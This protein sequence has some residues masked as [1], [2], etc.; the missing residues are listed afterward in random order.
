MS[1][2]ISLSNKL[3]PGCSGNDKFLVH[4]NGD[5][6][7][8]GD[9]SI[10][11]CIETGCI[12]TIQAADLP[13][14][15]T[16]EGHYK[17]EGHL[18]FDPSE[19]GVAIEIESDNVKLILDYTLC[20]TKSGDPTQMPFCIG[21]RVGV[22]RKCVTICGCGKICDFSQA[23]LVVGDIDTREP[24][25][26]S[27]LHLSGVTVDNCGRLASLQVRPPASETFGIPYRPSF[28]LEMGGV[29][30]S[31]ENFGSLG[32][33]ITMRNVN[34]TNN[35]YL[36][37]VISS[38]NGID[39]DNCH[40]DG[41]WTDDSGSLTDPDGPY[42]HLH[43]T[44]VILVSVKN[45]DA[46]NSTINNTDMDGAYSFSV[47]PTSNFAINPSEGGQGSIGFRC[48]F[49][50]CENV[51]LTNCNINGTRCTFAG[52]GGPFGIPLSA[53]NIGGGTNGVQCVDCTFDNCY[54]L[55]SQNNV[56]F[57]VDDGGNSMFRNCTSSN[58]E[59]ALG[60]CVPAPIITDYDPLMPFFILVTR[61]LVL[62]NCVAENNK[63]N[64][65]LNSFNRPNGFYFPVAFENFV[66][67]NCISKGMTATNGGW[68]D[69]FGIYSFGSTADS[70]LFEN[71]VASGNKSVDYTERQGNDWMVDRT[72]PEDSVIQL[73]FDPIVTAVVTITG[74][75][76]P[77]SIPVMST[78]GFPPS[79]FIVVLLEF[80]PFF[81]DFVFL[82]YSS[83]TATSFDG[84]TWDAPPF[85]S[86]I[87]IIGDT[88]FGA[89]DG[90]N[91]IS[92]ADGNIGNRPDLSP[93]DWVP[94]KTGKLVVVDPMAPPRLMKVE[95]GPVAGF[96]VYNFIGD[97]DDTTG[98]VT[99]KD[100]NAI[101]NKGP[102]SVVVESFVG[103][104]RHYSAGFRAN[105]QT[106]GPPGAGFDN[107]IVLD[108]CH[109]TDNTS[110][111]V[112]RNVDKCSVNECRVVNNDNYGVRFHGESTRNTVRNCYVNGNG[113]AGI[114]DDAVPSN[115]FVINNECIC[116]GS[117][118]ISNLSVCWP[119][120][121]P[122]DAGDLLVLPTSDKKYYNLSM[123]PNPRPETFVVDTVGAAPAG[124]SG[125]YFTC[126]SPSLD[127]YVWYDLDDGSADPLPGGAVP[128]SV[129]LDFTVGALRSFRL[130]NNVVGNV[131][132]SGA[133]DSVGAGMLSSVSKIQDGGGIGE[134]TD[135]NAAGATPAGL[136]GT[137]FLI[138]TTATDYYVW[139]DL[140]DGSVDPA[141]GGRTG[142]EV[143]IATGDSVIDIAE[144][145]ATAL[146]V[147]SGGTDFTTQIRL[148]GGSHFLISTPRN[149]Y[150]V[151][152]NLN[153]TSTDPDPGPPGI[154]GVEVGFSIS[155]S[156]VDIATTT[157]NELNGIAG[158]SEF[159]VTGP[160][161][162]VITV[163]NSDNGSV[164]P[165][166]EV[167][168]VLL[169]T[170]LVTGA[171]SIT[172]EV[173]IATGDSD[174]DIA[175]KTQAVLDAEADFKAYVFAGTKVVVSLTAN[176]G[177]TDAADVDTGMSVSVDTQGA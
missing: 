33:N 94:G 171:G 125:K 35:F 121:P 10:L 102:K 30:I 59:V 117:A 51:K 52:L 165:V 169:F 98:N 6:Q 161:G 133:G 28:P 153:G 38:Y 129:S 155:D 75:A 163:T 89:Y 12:T 97:R 70:H 106:F 120:T 154:I 65:P 136:D 170:P 78:F 157:A 21:V 134:I 115:T 151:W 156:A 152:Y 55:T 144:K 76:A 107:H 46:K 122:V 74:S 128:Q 39:A 88:I 2:P 5:V 15:I 40:V 36:G 141:V 50:P 126:S 177:A 175:T 19:P 25:D 90:V 162:T 29:F 16:E 71:C 143:D 105:P 60:F 176:G 22:D 110:G 132:D 7:I 17:L 87:T 111:I 73:R 18:D 69:G 26:N 109:S 41:T 11:G 32:K 146:A 57:A 44:G 67:R 173:D 85:A 95:A 116:N 43:P 119:G 166:M 130:Q 164:T 100:C 20:Q 49:V 13:F 82:D 145:T 83:L 127:F 159:N 80:A 104:V 68:V 77:T 61:N 103:P 24:S 168:T 62:E 54:S 114:V 31:G 91:Y 139:Y 14:L 112:M 140:D 149:D 93:G 96:G 27:E 147:W 86:G 160:V 58:N 63:I 9:V 131:T 81:A 64:G 47:D 53:I 4:K 48:G 148:A 72:Y 113:C 8:R 137:H 42:E 37:L 79:G 56:F 142:I 158:G 138:S 118:D 108:G 92:L 135:I 124:L 123:K 1:D 167:D 45:F 99:F 34:I 66:V 84:V 3:F 174:A 150:Y 172:I 23:G 101:H